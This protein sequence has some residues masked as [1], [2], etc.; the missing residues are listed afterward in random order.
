MSN[1][2]PL[3]FL[4]IN[5]QPAWQMPELPSLRK[6]PAHATF[7]PFP[8]AQAAFG[9]VAEQ[10]PLVQSLNGNWD[11]TLFDTPREVTA[12]AL[13]AAPW[14]QLAVPGNWTMQL[15]HEPWDG[16]SFMRPHYTNIQM[17]FAE[18]FP[19][20]PE[21]IATGVYRTRFR[22]PTAWA[23]Q[24]VV[25]HFAGCEGALFIY[26]NGAFVGFNK[27]SR[28]PAEYDITE[29]V[30]LGG[31]YELLCVN[32][33]YSD[34]SWL[35]DQDHWWQA[36]I[37]RDVYLY[38][39]PTTFLQDIAVQTDLA[40]DFSAGTLR[41][42]TTVRTLGQHASG[43]IHMQLFT[44]DGSAVF[45]TPLTSSVPGAPTGFPM[46]R[47]TSDTANATLVATIDQPACWNTETPH[48]YTLI[49][50]LD[51]A[52]TSISTAVRIG[53][54]TVDITN[55]ELRVNRQ[56][57]FVHGVN[58]HEHSD[59]FGK[60]VPRELMER[61]IKTMKAHNINA[62][63][64]SHYPNHPYW[65]DLCDQYGL[66]VV[67]EAN[68]EHHAL[69]RLSQES[70][71][72]AAYLERV[73]NMVARDKNHPSVIVWSLGNESGYGINHETSAA[74][75]RHTDPTRPIQYE[76][77]VSPFNNDQSITFNGT[78]DHWNRGHTVT[79]IVAPMY[80]PISDIVKWVS[81]TN[82]P[83]PL[84]LCEYAHA[85]GNSSGSLADY[86]AAFEQHHGLQGGFIWEWLDHGIRMHT[87]AGE[88]YWVYGGSFGDIPNDGNF[89]ADG[90][91]WPDRMPH[92]GMREFMYLARPVRITAS[93][94]A[95]GVFGIENRRFY[96]TLAD[97]HGT[98][99]IVV[100]GTV[101]HTGTVAIPPIAPQSAGTIT[102]PVQWPVSGEA[103][104]EFSFATTAASYWA[105]AGQV[106]A[107]D[108]I[109]GPV[110][111][112]A[113][114]PQSATHTVSSVSQTHLILTNN[115]YRVV[116]DRTTGE[117][118]DFNQRQA[119]MA[120]PQLNL[121][122]APTDNDHL[123][124][125][126]AMM[127]LQAYPLW[128]SVGLTQL[129]YRVTA[130]QPIVT[131]S[132]EHC[133]EVHTC[134]SGRER[135]DD[136]QTTHIYTLTDTGSLRIST[137]VVLAPDLVD[138]P[139]IGITLQLDPAF[140]TISWYGRGPHENYSDRNASS[141][142]GTYHST[143]SDQYTPYIMPQENGHKGDVRWLSLTDN[144]GQTLTIRG[145]ALFGFNALH[146]RDADLEAA[147]FTPDLHARP[148]IILNLNHGMRGL[149]TGLMVDTLPHYQL[150]EHEYH[151]TFELRW[152]K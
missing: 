36:G 11:F 6:L 104:I 131:A 64:C 109:A 22:V 68:I 86:Y 105:P 90:M 45:P 77:A 52:G 69:L 47:T 70:R 71:V 37:H 130:V 3:P 129:Q 136:I 76:G 110:I 29:L 16:E 150:H 74:W 141:M 21:S 142:V 24:R 96:T 97:L 134:A 80:A 12:D 66:F 132:G 83:R 106:V 8:S 101:T 32:P 81:T 115:H 137:H 5:E 123:Q 48:L 114:M 113:T 124:E 116:V 79:D 23:E 91:V 108:Q 75:I 62:V 143:V 152:D 122:R 67:D 51:A 151:F 55:R 125:M 95:N 54:R 128:R 41:V 25:L 88:P 35:E 121:W 49:V 92:P 126:F 98:W 133:I 85:M 111:P 99:R 31:E 120:G 103:F 147:K 44:A 89:V 100:D 145:D 4:L 60:A 13:T 138:L 1:Q 40:D 61:D 146:Y 57:I 117:L 118:S 10:S 119:I 14:R 63:R 87:P 38:T 26:L 34:A 39:T 17:P 19:H 82:D 107:W 144:T 30:Q 127:R 18:N 33:R 112:P 46:G 140:E 72:S 28:T 20:L 15:R 58:Y 94:S 50:T 148:E 7:W 139:R 43:T 2:T 53:F 102:I 56:P 149:G 78:L 84:I 73:S 59:E 65:L 42:H 135:W 9:R 27:D 93:D